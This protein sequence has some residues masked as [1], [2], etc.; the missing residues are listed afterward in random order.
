MEPESVAEWVHAVP[1]KPFR[2]FL[3]SGRRYDVA[4]PDFIDVG[5]DSA[6]FFYR[7]EPGTHQH[8]KREMFALAQI[9]H[10]EELD[11]ASQ[12]G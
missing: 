12:P 9:D 6:I 7:R 8:Y 3:S 2:I 5:V 10:I 1:F 11:T 4:H